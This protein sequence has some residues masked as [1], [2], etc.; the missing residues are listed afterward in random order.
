ML[1][2][3]DDLTIDMVNL[4]TGEEKRVNAGKKSKAGET[5]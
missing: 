1:Y 4:V 5:R 2:L 3:N